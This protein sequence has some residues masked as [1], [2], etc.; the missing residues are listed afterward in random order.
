MDKYSYSTLTEIDRCIKDEP[1]QFDY[2]EIII[3]AAQNYNMTIHSVTNQRPL[4]ILFNK[5]KHDKILQI[6]K[7]AQEKMLIF[8]NKDRKEM[9]FMIRNTGNR[10]SLSLDIKNR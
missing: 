6:L 4:E 8:Y 3:R 9:S 2:L 5:I 10:I 1:N 7:Q